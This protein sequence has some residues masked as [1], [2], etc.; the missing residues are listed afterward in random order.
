MEASA[1]PEPLLPQ[2][3]VLSERAPI[4]AV[5]YLIFD[6]FAGIGGARYALDL[7]GLK[8]AAHV[9]SL[10]FETDPSCRAL[11]ARLV[12][13]DRCFLSSAADSGGV[14]GSVLALTDDDC[15]L[16]R[17]F[18]DKYPNLK[19]VLFIGGFPC[20]GL[21]RAN[22]HGRGLSDHRS[23]LVWTFAVLVARARAHLAARSAKPS[24]HFLVENVCMDPASRNSISCLL[25]AEPRHIDAAVCSP[26]A[27][28]RMYWTSL[29]CDSPPS[30]TVS[31]A[32]VLD[33][34]WAPLWTRTG[35]PPNFGRSE[36]RWATVTRPFPAGQPSEFPADFPRLALRS[37]NEHGLAFYTQAAPEQLAHVDS[38]VGNLVRMPATSVASDLTK[39]GSI[40]LKRRGELSRLVHRS[41]LGQVLRPLGAREVERALGYPA[42]ASGSD[43]DDDLGRLRHL[44]NGFSV[45][46][47]SHLLKD[48]VHSALSSSIP[49]V[50]GPGPTALTMDTAIGQLAGA[51]GR[52]FPPA[53][54][55]PQ[56]A[57]PSRKHGSTR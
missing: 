29:K 1:G 20:Q 28:P 35:A 25:G 43:V 34:G 42:G 3:S 32:E 46:V 11:L 16:A 18:L 37:Y 10:V 17:S 36:H 5:Q 38:V 24:V 23:V 31:P 13:G 49:S 27:R 41:P 55:E 2:P 44:G 48:F 21:S 45:F 22:P 8:D 26:M 50:H 15:R 14:V 9:H 57:P 19:A 54:A 40:F 52:M 56:A 7:A 39:Q 4:S 53:P 51:R 33:A 47:V 30:T 12:C 6:L